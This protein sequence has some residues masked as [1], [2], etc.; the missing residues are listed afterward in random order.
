MPVQRAADTASSPL[1]VDQG[2]T[3]DGGEHSTSAASNSTNSNSTD[4][5]VIADD[6]ATPFPTA[7]APLLG[8]SADSLGSRA[9]LDRCCPAAFLRRLFRTLRSSAPS[10]QLGRRHRFTAHPPH[11]PVSAHPSL[12]SHRPRRRA[13]S[14]SW[15]EKCPCSGCSSPE[16][17]PSP[18]GQHIPTVQ[19]RWS[20]GR[21][22]H[23][24]PVD[25]HAAARSDERD[26]D[27]AQRPPAL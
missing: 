11:R 3:S 5:M 2:V 1:T 19:T 10:R 27:P 13:T 14:S 20:S 8:D 15:P 9:L 12:R 24:P 16:P 7:V 6:W 25:Q 22:P 18:A 26:T 4:S 23:N 17:R 21:R